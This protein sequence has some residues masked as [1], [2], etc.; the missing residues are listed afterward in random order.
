MTE[1]ERKRRIEKLAGFV[2]PKGNYTLQDHV[3]TSHMSVVYKALD[4]ASRRYVAIK[5][6]L[7]EKF[8]WRF[9]NEFELSYDLTVTNI[10][11]TTRADLVGEIIFD[12]DGDIVIK[13]LVMKWLSGL[14]LLDIIRKNREDPK[15]TQQLLEEALAILRKLAPALDTIHQKNIYHRDIKPSNIRFNNDTNER[16]EPYL[17]DFGIAKKGHIEETTLVVARESTTV[18]EYTGTPRYMPPEQWDGNV[19]SGASD[20]YALA[21]T[22]YELLS[23]GTSP[24]RKSMQSTSPTSPSGNGSNPANVYAWQ[25]AHREAEPTSIKE[26]RFDVP[27]A[28]W[29]ILKQAMSKDA[30]Q[31]YEN[32]KLFQEAFQSAVHPYSPKPRLNAP[33]PNVQQAVYHPPQDAPTWPKNVP[34]PQ[35]RSRTPIIGA[36]IFIIVGIIGALIVL[37]SFLATPTATPTVIVSTSPTTPTVIAATNE[38]AVAIIPTATPTIPSDTPAH[39]LTPAQEAT[40]TSQPPSATPV[41]PAAAVVIP[42]TTPSPL[43]PSPTSTRTPVPS[44]TPMPSATSTPSQ[45]PTRVP[46]NT[47]IPPTATTTPSSTPTRTPT[48]L[49]TATHTPMPTLTATLTAT[50]M[51]KDFVELLDQITRA[52]SSAARFDCAGYVE[53][54][55]GLEDAVAVSS[56]EVE[57]AIIAPIV[58]DG[59]ET[60]PV[61]YEFCNREQN[62]TQNSIQLPSNISNNQFR[63]LRGVIGEAKRAIQ[64][65]R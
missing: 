27:E 18:G 44:D 31:R 7:D 21:I 22:I 24:F 62:R 46:S 61:L 20:Q 38:A 55:E 65:L 12:G 52:G 42:T 1:V 40:H 51:V 35:T 49:P 5:I 41:P 26:Y 29:Q 43:P 28:V 16:N 64:N 56:V 34:V 59:A 47:P 23:D 19:N 63:D 50:P 36:I 10:A 48:T 8:Y 11:V 33:M 13:Y 37:P 15:P 9:E 6:L 39:T 57:V 58:E 30:S 3:A 2:L 17:L 14:S 53:A 32:I 45:T 54:Y 25:K 4:N 60:L